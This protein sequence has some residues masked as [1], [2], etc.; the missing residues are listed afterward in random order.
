MREEPIQIEGWI[1]DIK[2]DDKLA[3]SVSESLKNRQ[4]LPTEEVKALEKPC[5]LFDKTLSLFYCPH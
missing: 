1:R 3:I 2:D 4:E 5:K